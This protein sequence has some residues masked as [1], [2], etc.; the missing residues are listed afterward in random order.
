LPTDN[1]KPYA[2]FDDCFGPYNA[3]L[4][5]ITRTQAGERGRVYYSA[6]G[7]AE[8]MQ[9]F[10]EV[11]T[12]DAPLQKGIVWGGGVFVVSEDGWWQIYGTN[13][14]FSRSISGVPGTTQ[15][16]TVIGVPG[17]IMYEAP[18][19]VRLFTGNSS[20]LVSTKQDIQRI[21]RGKTGGALTAF[22]GVVAEYG[23]GEYLISDETQL[24]ALNVEGGTWRDIGDLAV[25]A[26][27]YAKDADIMGAGTN[28]DGIYDLE[29][30]GDTQDNATDI[31]RDIETDRVRIADDKTNIM[32]HVHVD[33]EE[34]S[35]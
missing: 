10:I 13:P 14:Y 22:T 17:G 19:G 9:G 15:P 16:H 33:Y 8:A 25:K 29:N 20:R 26:L 5:W 2:W 6:I 1:D 3:S 23:R 32:L 18:D 28:A 12:D 31:E 4:F 27:H 24:I 34:E 11:G 21:F 7:R 35:N 30:E